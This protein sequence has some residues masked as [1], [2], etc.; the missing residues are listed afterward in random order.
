[1]TRI[2][3]P[4]L[5]KCGAKI[6]LFA[7]DLGKREATSATQSIFRIDDAV[8][9]RRHLSDRVPLIRA[10]LRR[11]HIRSRGD[12]HFQF[13]AHLFFFSAMILKIFGCNFTMRH[14]YRGNFFVASASVKFA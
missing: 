6:L 7:T 12:R 5:E 9:S 2:V 8:R 3:A 13:V 10:H 11:Y 14:A 4:H 1:M